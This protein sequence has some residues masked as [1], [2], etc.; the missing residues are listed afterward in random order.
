[1]ISVVESERKTRKLREMCCVFRVVWVWWMSW[2]SGG[3]AGMENVVL[4]DRAACCLLS[5]RS[6]SGFEGI[7]SVFDS[8]SLDS[9]ERW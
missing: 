3:V 4:T 6:S 7:D 5:C 9:M 1:M 8:A 2:S